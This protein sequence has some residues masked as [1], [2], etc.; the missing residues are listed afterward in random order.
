MRQ[1]EKEVT[2]KILKMLLGDDY[3]RKAGI[4]TDR[5]T[6]YINIMSDET[7]NQSKKIEQPE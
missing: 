4:F 7:V 3:A 2:E 6:V 5:G 1:D